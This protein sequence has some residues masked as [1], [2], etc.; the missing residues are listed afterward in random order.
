MKTNTFIIIICVYTLILGI[1]AIFFPSLALEYFAGDPNDQNQQSLFNFIGAYQIAL[2]YL[3]YTAYKSTNSS[4]RKA[5][6]LATAFLTIIAVIFVVYN[7]KVRQLA[8]GETY[9]VDIVVWLILAAGS[10][11]FRSKE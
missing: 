8:V 7:M 2:A 11:Y 1:S 9:M 10:L 5:F 4:T 6:L 3:G